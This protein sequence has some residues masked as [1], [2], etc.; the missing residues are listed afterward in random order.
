MGVGVIAFKRTK[1][2]NWGARHVDVP[3]AEPCSA[4]EIPMQCLHSREDA[5]G[6]SEAGI[7]SFTV[8]G[9]L[10]AS[11][12]WSK[13]LC[14]SSTG[15]SLA[16][17]WLRDTASNECGTQS[18]E[19]L[20]PP[21]HTEPGTGVHLGIARSRLSEI[22]SRADEEHPDGVHPFHRMTSSDCPAN[23]GGDV[24][25]RGGNRRG[26]FSGGHLRGAPPKDA[27]RPVPGADVPREE[28]R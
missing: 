13:P 26:D 22:S 27:W 18:T 14:R 17:L 10:R 9:G 15:L 21:H 24:R 4:H 8:S 6:R 2:R 28:P 20:P 16:A 25:K 23:P 11:F 19:A 5:A 1:S 12:L 7:R 3:G